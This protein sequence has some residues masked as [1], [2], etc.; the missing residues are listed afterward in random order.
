[1]FAEY[2]DQSGE[3]SGQHML[4]P[5]FSMPSFN[6][7][8]ESSPIAAPTPRRG[9]RRGAGTRADTPTRGKRGAQVAQSSTAPPLSPPEEPTTPGRGRGRGRGAPKKAPELPSEDEESLYNIILSGKHSL[10]V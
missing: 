4:D 3:Q 9:G 1:M 5:T 6:S 10:Q 2:E 7:T 8:L